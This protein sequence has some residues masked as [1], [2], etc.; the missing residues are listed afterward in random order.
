MGANAMPLDIEKGL[1]AGFFEYLTKPVKVN[2]LLNALDNAL[3]F[4]KMKL[5]NTY[6]NGQL[7]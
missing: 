2:E 7:R 4:S 5:I 6:K 3:K 1:E